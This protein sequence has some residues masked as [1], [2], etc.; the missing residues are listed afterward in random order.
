MKSEKLN[1]DATSNFTQKYNK[2]NP[3]Y[4]DENAFITR[5]TEDEKEINDRR[6]KSMEEEINHP[7]QEDIIVYNQTEESK[8]VLVEKDFLEKL[9]DFEYWKEWKNQ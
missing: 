8:T 5:L 6:V 9:K 4:K 2:D 7:T 3:Y 1:Q